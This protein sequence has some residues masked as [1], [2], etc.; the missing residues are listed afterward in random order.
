MLANLA[1]RCVQDVS[2]LANLEPKMGN[3]ARFWEH[4]GDF[5]LD[6]GGDLARTGENQKTD[7]STALLKVFW[8]LGGALG[9]H[10]SSS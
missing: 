8:G 5:F 10:V 1:P 4:L 7:D 6:D 9:G 2:K 3:L